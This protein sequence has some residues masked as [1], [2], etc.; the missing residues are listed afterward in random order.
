MENINQDVENISS[1]SSHSSD[2]V[3]F[4]DDPN[5]VQLVER[6]DLVG[7]WPPQ[8]SLYFPATNYPQAITSQQNHQTAQLRTNPQNTPSIS[9]LQTSTTQKCNHRVPHQT[10]QPNTLPTTQ[11][12]ANKQ[13]HIQQH[14]TQEQNL[15]S[16][17]NPQIKA[18]VPQVP[19]GQQLPP[20]TTV[21][22]HF[23]N[24]MPVFDIPNLFH[25]TNGAI[26]INLP[27]LKS[28]FPNFRYLALVKH[29]TH[30][31]LCNCIKNFTAHDPDILH[32]ETPN[33]TALAYFLQCFL[34]GLYMDLM[35]Q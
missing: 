11:Q 26:V 24:L 31:N 14:S 3:Q 34:A 22:L 30:T 10:T 12:T 28:H 5:L 18:T 4:I 13:Q 19:K 35:H 6:T 33:S 23:Q 7:V 27:L 20:K 1:P 9:H 16:T 15:P 29:L 17:S 8:D 32:I 2:D 25:V 21:A